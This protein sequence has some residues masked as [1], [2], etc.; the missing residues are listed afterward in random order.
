MS[1]LYGAELALFT[2]KSLVLRRDAAWST[3]Q[4]LFLMNDF[5]H[6]SHLHIQLVKWKILAFDSVT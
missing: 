1:G 3:Q 6:S 5:I 4:M 2:A